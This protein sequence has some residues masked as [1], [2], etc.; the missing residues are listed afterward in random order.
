MPYIL[1]SK[2]GKYVDMEKFFSN[3]YKLT[4]FL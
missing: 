2:I 4:V 1:D 3:L